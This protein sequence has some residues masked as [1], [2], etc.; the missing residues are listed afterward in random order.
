MEPIKISEQQRLAFVKAFCSATQ[1]MIFRRVK[2]TVSK[3]ENLNCAIYCKPSHQGGE[4]VVFDYYP[5]DQADLKRFSVDEMERKVEARFS[6]FFSFTKE[7]RLRD[8]PYPHKRIFLP[9]NNYAEFD[10]LILDWEKTRSA[11]VPPKYNDLVCILPGDPAKNGGR[12]FAAKWF[13]CSEQFM[14]AWTAL[15][16]DYHESFEANGK[17]PRMRERLM[18]GNRL[19]TNS[20]LKYVLSCQQSMIPIKKDELE[21]RYFR[22]R[23]ESWAREYCHN[24]ALLVLIGRYGELPCAANVPNNRGTGTPNIQEPLP[25]CTKWNIHPALVTMWTGCKDSWSDC[26][27]LSNPYNEY[28]ATAYFLKNIAKP[29]TAETWQLAWNGFFT[30]SDKSWADMVE[31]EDDE[32]KPIENAWNR[33]IPLTIKGY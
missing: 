33:P 19:T 7:V 23:C 28:R 4:S 13:I 24:Y 3:I 14:R 26:V 9:S 8:D 32:D 5:A 16:Y 31:E 17:E 1:N 25:L 21:K 20:Y 29:R 2:N 6:F 18:S 11:A 22:L 10:L 15:H 27:W 30:Q 12:P